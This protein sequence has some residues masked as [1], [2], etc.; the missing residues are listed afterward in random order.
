MNS[1]SWVNGVT[2]SENKIYTLLQAPKSLRVYEAREPFALQKIINIDEVQ[3]PEDL[4]YSTTSNCLYITDEDDECIWKIDLRNDRVT[5][6]LFPMS[7]PFTLSMSTEGYVLI[8]KG[9]IIS[10]HLEIYG[11]DAVLQRRIQL[12]NEIR[13]PQHAIQTP[14]GDFIISHS[15]ILP[16]SKIWV[17]SKVSSDGQVLSKYIPLNV[18][19]ECRAPCHLAYDPV[20]NRMFVL[21]IC[22]HKVT[23][24]DADFRWRQILLSMDTHD[25]YIPT[26]VSYNPQKSQLIVGLWGNGTRVFQ[27][28]QGIN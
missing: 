28:S 13:E 2:Y 6:W 8:L 21:D 23:L 14:T 19:E 11:S 9:N 15:M 25:I 16:P 3:N 18:S 10:W 20:N 1:A 5:K 12:P 4:A 24:L 17:I 27:I 26:R 22:G 7:E